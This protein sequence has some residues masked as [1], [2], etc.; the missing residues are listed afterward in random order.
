MKNVFSI[1]SSLIF[2]LSI[3]AYSQNQKFRDKLDYKVTYELTYKMD[4]TAIDSAKSEYMILSVGDE[5]SVFSSSA[6]TI[7]NRYIIKGNM[8]TTNPAALTQFQYVIFK[9]AETDK[10]YYTLQIPKT[11]DRFYYVQEKDLFNWEI[12]PETKLIEGYKTQ[13]ATT[14]FAGRNYV[15]WFTPEI[16]IPEGPY[17]FNGLPGL[18]LEIADT[19]GHYVF[20]FIGLEELSPAVPFKIDL[21]HYIETEKEKLLQNFYRYRRDP[22]TYDPNPNVQINP[23]THKALVEGFT[24]MLEKENNPI[25]LE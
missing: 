14:S 5:L 12:S 11:S 19:K 18:I 3:S 4:S 24:K 8:G 23:E 16:P 21:N 17:K 15:A 7:A 6:K 13:K 20:K 9:S 25:E 10:I 22:F 2:F 1:L